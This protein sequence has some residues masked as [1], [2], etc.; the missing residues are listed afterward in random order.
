MAGGP[1]RTKRRT[2][3]NQRTVNIRA[4]QRDREFI[5]VTVFLL[6]RT[7][8]T[9]ILEMMERLRLERMDRR[10]RPGAGGATVLPEMTDRE[11]V[12]E[13]NWRL[14]TLPPG[15]AE[16]V[17]RYVRHL[18]RWYTERRKKAARARGWQAMSTTAP[19]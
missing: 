11:V 8:K 16:A 3:L 9:R 2:R 4:L 5:K 18:T 14:G 13:I 7:I 19:R 15:D 17:A 6:P 12:R 1:K 10:L